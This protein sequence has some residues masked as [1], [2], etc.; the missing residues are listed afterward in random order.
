[1]VDGDEVPGKVWGPTWLQVGEIA[2]TPIGKMTLKKHTGRADALLMA[3][4]GRTP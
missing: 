2:L 4:Y 3:E 1:M